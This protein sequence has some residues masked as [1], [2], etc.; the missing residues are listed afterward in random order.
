MATQDPIPPDTPAAE[1]PSLTHK[2]TAE[3]LAPRHEE[4]NGST[5]STASTSSRHSSQPSSPQSSTTTLP[6]TITSPSDNTCAAPP[7]IPRLRSQ[8]SIKFAPLPE[9]A[10]TAP[11]RHPPLGIATR[12][13]LMRRRKLIA[14]GTAPEAE[15]T[16]I[17]HVY[18]PPAADA[19]GRR[20]KGRA[21]PQPDE[22]R[23]WTREDLASAPRFIEQVVAEHEA[24]RVRR[25]AGYESSDT[26]DEAHAGPEDAPGA[27]IGRIVK[28]ARKHLFRKA[29]NKELRQERSAPPKPPPLP[30]PGQKLLLPP[31]PPAPT[32]KP[33]NNDDDHAD[34]HA[35][36]KFERA[37]GETEGA[38][39]DE[40]VSDPQRFAAQNRRGL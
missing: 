28:G 26:E 38:V 27:T 20:A 25:R 10:R 13:Q 6:S 39:W 18:R 7:P 3:L 31:P 24:R 11:R 34:P 22:E 40:E 14:A 4:D 36:C 9:P 37:P 19:A 17:V 23:G 21:A 33:A 15:E 12:G 8:P 2:D 1:R 5:N 35:D 16:T 32:P 30:R 29:S